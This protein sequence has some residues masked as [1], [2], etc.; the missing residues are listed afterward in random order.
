MHTGTSSPPQDLQCKLSVQATDK[1]EHTHT[2]ARFLYHTHTHIR[3][4]SYL[5]HIPVIRITDPKIP[6]VPAH[7]QPS[8]V[9][10]SD[11]NTDYISVNLKF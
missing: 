3:I 6:S 11:C 8:D 5:Y 7:A 9:S 10:V 2:H 1:Q 4:N